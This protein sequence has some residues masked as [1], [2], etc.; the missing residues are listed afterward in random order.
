MSCGR[1]SSGARKIQPETIAKRLAAA[2]HEITRWNSYDYV[3][4]ND[5][6]QRTFGD[7]LAILTAERL[8][9]VRQEA[10]VGAFVDQLLND[11]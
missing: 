5:D 2:R 9:R 1:G 8:R 11:A 3:L 4:V 6:L 7:I 10:G